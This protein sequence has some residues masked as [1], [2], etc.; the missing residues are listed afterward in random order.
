[1][2]YLGFEPHGTSDAGR[3]VRRARF[4]DR[5]NLPVSAA[6]VVANGMRETLSSL[7]HVA[8]AAS[9]FEPQLPDAA[10]WAAIGRG[11]TCHRVRGP[12]ADAAIV[13]RPA[14]AAALIAAAFGER[15]DARRA[16][17]PIEREVLARIV[18]GLAATLA[19]VNGCTGELPAIVAQSD[20]SG[21]T[22][23]FEIA[24]AHPTRATIGVALAADP[25]PP[26][27]G[28]LSID[29]LAPVEVDVSVRFA[30]ARVAAGLAA[31]QTGAV[32]P[33]PDAPGNIYLDGCAIARAECGA[34]GGRYA[35]RL[36][37][38]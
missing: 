15:I 33:M 8:V 5:S 30:C 9:V 12:L 31:L 23:Y 6:C 19:P 7:L 14:D 18:R 25:V 29:D 17:S 2:K 38:V 11:A 37:E 13:L 32:L 35:A 1:V 36:C 28:R 24:V 4:E 26:T 22:T 27:R 10:G 34:L 21:F 20:A 16:F 3:C